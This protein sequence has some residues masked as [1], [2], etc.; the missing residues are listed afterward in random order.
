VFY[1]VPITMITKWY[2]LAVT[3]IGGILLVVIF[4][5]LPKM[6]PIIDSDVTEQP[7]SLPPEPTIA[8]EIIG[9]SV[10]GRPI[11]VYE[12]GDGFKNIVLVGGMHGGYEWNT[13]LLAYE[14]I[15]F[16]TDNIYS[17]PEDI[18]ISIIP[19]SNPD[20][21]ARV[22]SG[23]RTGRFRPIDVIAWSADGRGRLNANGVD[24]NRNFDCRWTIDARWRN[25]PVSAGAGPFSEPESSTLRDYILDRQP[26]AAVFWHSAANT[27][28]GAS[29]GNVRHPDTNDIMNR[30]ASAARYQ[31]KPIFDAYPISGDVEGWLATVGIPA[32][33]VELETR[34][35]TEW[36]RN[37]AGV[38]AVIQYFTA[39]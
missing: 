10:E 9:Y 23:N 15:D 20:G 11:E 17:I 30:Y 22:T 29:C 33:T 25:Q 16:F 35:N 24:I 1:T 8:T 14:M 2:P 3:I 26:V 34:N 7:I 28:F 12:F 38:Q 39:L 4:M 18:K 31:A 6:Q 5:L 36:N 37:L 32:I 19:N 21:L 13:I 27:V